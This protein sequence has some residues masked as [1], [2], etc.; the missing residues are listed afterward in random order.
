MIPR[1]DE[2]QRGPS[3]RNQKGGHIENKEHLGMGS[4]CWSTLD[5][6]CG[7]LTERVPETS[8]DILSVDRMNKP[9]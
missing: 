6:Y 5:L 9:T 7:Q 2:E 1:N 3:C 4:L 8:R